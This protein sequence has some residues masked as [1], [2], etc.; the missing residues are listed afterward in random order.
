[1]DQIRTL[2]HF[3]SA[4][5]TYI[6][7]QGDHGLLGDPGVVGQKGEKGIVGNTGHQGPPGWLLSALLLLLLLLLLFVKIIY[8][9]V[10]VIVVV[11]T[12]NYVDTFSLTTCLPTTSPMLILGNNLKHKYNI[13]LLFNTRDTGEA[14]NKGVTG[15]VW[16]WAT[17]ASLVY[18][19]RFL[20]RTVCALVC[21]INVTCVYVTI[22]NSGILSVSVVLNPNID[23]SAPEITHIHEMCVILNYFGY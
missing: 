17:E 10:V 5:D 9:F 3:K 8:L 14:S 11:V 21:M 22:C 16:S 13:L 18:P 19:G 23:C 1:M 20:T 15:G 7:F 2:S 6:C 12:T 4:A